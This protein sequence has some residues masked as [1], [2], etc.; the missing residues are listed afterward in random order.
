MTSRK[1]QR[2]AA[3]DAL[4]GTAI[5][6]MFF[7]HFSWDLAYFGFTDFQVVTNP[8]WM[9]FARFIA[10]TIL[11]VMGISQGIV[12]KREFD[13]RAFLRRLAIITACAATISIGTYLMDPGVFIFFGVLHHIALVSILMLLAVRLP[14][15]TLGLL[16]AFC[17]IVPKFFTH[18][19]FF[20]KWL[21]WVGLTPVS[22]PAL[23]YV[24]LLPWFAVSLIGVIVGRYLFTGSGP[25]ILGAW[26][27]M[28]A[29]SRLIH[30]AGRHSLLLYMI[31]QPILFGAVYGAYRVLNM[32]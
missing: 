24:P 2:Y 11:L 5:W 1:L 19:I 4:R 30:L 21:W 9:W 10:G 3:I 26:Q 13:L 31:H 23:D 29:A 6:L 25:R 27:P 20:A 12:S 18:E 14:T 8:Y 15:A 22:P 28:N 17:L 16:A 32:H 7:Y